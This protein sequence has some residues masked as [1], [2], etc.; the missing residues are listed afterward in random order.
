MPNL[1]LFDAICRGEPRGEVAI[2]NAKRDFATLTTIHRPTESTSRVWLLANHGS[3]YYGQIAFPGGSL[4]GGRVATC[5]CND[6]PMDASMN[7]PMVGVKVV[8]LDDAKLPK[9][10]F[11]GFELTMPANHAGSF[12][13]HV[14][15]VWIAH[16]R[17]DIGN[18]CLGAHNADDDTWFCVDESLHTSSKDASCA[19][20]IKHTRYV[21][22][23]HYFLH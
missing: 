17:T 14:A 18:Y 11:G 3:A 1:N 19:C 16:M 20:E 15:Q 12:A 6:A 13:P 22:N 21:V 7:D 10:A 4:D 9:G 23:F 5:P 2:E 8:A